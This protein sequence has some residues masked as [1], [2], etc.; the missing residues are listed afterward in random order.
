MPSQ[1]GVLGALALA[2]SAAAAYAAF[3]LTAPARRRKRQLREVRESPARPPQQSRT[4]H[5]TPATR[6]SARAKNPRPAHTLPNTQRRVRVKD[7]GWVAMCDAL[8]LQDF[9]AGLSA[10]LADVS[11]LGA[12]EGPG[13]D[14][15]WSARLARRA[16]AMAA[17]AGDP[18]A[19]RVEIV[20]AVDEATGRIVGTGRLLLEPKLTRDLG[21]VAHIE[22]VGTS[23]EA[24]GRGVGS[25]VLSE[26]MRRAGA[27]GAY[28][29]ILD[30]SLKNAPFYER[31]GFLRKEIQM[32]KYL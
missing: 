19:P 32:A 9:W 28:K 7:G 26:L 16:R 29:V 27:A 18:D 24:R 12:P 20:V 2:S 1:R 25:A 21:T 5:R 15:A 3:A 31:C 23:P 10:S 6:P 14:R 17:C 13:A 8:P 4:A 11:T 22:D 30:C